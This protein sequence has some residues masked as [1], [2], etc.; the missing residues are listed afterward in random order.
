QYYDNYVTGI[1][2]DNKF[3]VQNGEA[4]IPHRLADYKV[5]PNKIIFDNLT[6]SDYYFQTDKN[7]VTIVRYYRN[8][9]VSFASLFS[10]SMLIF[11]LVWIIIYLI[12]YYLNLISRNLKFKLKIHL[13]LRTKI[14]GTIG[15][16]IL[17]AFII[18]SISTYYLLSIRNKQSINTN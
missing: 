16:T 18:I 2:I 17:I 4:N 10:Y 1:F 7:I 8:H 15:G 12:R 6:Y 9:L 3:I 5:N 11:L 14:N 13:S